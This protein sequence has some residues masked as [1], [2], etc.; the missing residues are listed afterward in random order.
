MH[1]EFWQWSL[2]LLAGFLV[3]LS[4]AGIKGINV[5]TVTL[6]AFSF[7]GKV[8]TGILLPMLIAGDTFAVLYYNRHANWTYLKKLL[9][10]MLVGVLLGVYFGKDLPEEIFRKGMAAIIL[11]TV[12]MMLWYDRNQKVSIPNNHWFAGVMG[13][14]AGFTTM[15]GNLAG[16]FSNIYFLAMR[17]PKNEFIGT[18]AWLF[19]IINLFKLPFHIIVWKTIN[20]TS[21]KINL[22]LLPALGLGLCCGI[23]L[24]KKINDDFFRKMILV[25]TAIG[26]VVMMGR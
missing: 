23:F 7:G 21:L 4:K 13:L 16:A 26:A 15:I 14:G 12:L 18:A 11:L 24:V 3:G 2:A 1:L 20:L 25:L 22:W 17:L 9:P 8:S 5:L 6:L 10:W 19:F